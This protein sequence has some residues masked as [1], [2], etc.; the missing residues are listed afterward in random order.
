MREIERGGIDAVRR[1]SGDLDDWNPDSF[2]VDDDAYERAAADLDEGLREHIAFAQQR[3]GGFARAQRATLTDLEVQLGEGV[4][5]GHRHIPV[6]RVGAYVPG[7]RY[8]MLASSFMT[9]LVAKIAGVEQVIGCAPPQHDRGIHPAML[10]AMRSS[11]ADAV[12]CLGWV[13]ALA[14]L[15]LGLID[16]IRPVDMLVGAGNTFVAEA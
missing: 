13:Q 4:T 2:L 8:P 3:V 14:A 10:Y 9:I 7:G 6:Q 15:S 16:G 5:L 1:W 12:I 11:G